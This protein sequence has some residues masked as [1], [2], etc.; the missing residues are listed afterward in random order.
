M[1][2]TNKLRF[3]KRKTG[4]AVRDP[5]SAGQTQHCDHAL[6]TL[7]CQEDHN[8]F[9]VVAACYL[10]SQAKNKE[11]E[12]Q[13]VARHDVANDCAEEIKLQ[14]KEIAALQAQLAELREKARASLD[15]LK[16]SREADA[17]YVLS[18]TESRLNTML[19]AHAESAAADAA[20]REL[21]K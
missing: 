1:T 2:P 7:I 11:L 12:A 20:L 9:N 13:L 14:R 5:N 6:A 10:D 17:Y 16:Q 18:K 3:V 15:A 4:D 19:D 21:L 8:E